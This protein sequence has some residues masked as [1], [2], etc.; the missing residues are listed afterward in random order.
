[1]KFKKGDQIIITLGKDRGKKGKIEKVFPGENKIMVPGVNIF[2]K[3]VRPR[4]EGQPGGI[5]DVVR[6]LSVAKIALVCPRCSRATR[7]GF[8][9]TGSKADKKDKIRIC[10]K[11][12]AII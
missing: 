2:K 12:K 6:P 8:H 4:G 7:I 10:R 9:P 5:T 11:C 1:M 3:H